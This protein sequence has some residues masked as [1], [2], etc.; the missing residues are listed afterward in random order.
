MWG[1]DKGRKVGGGRCRRDKG[2]S[3][4]AKVYGVR[5][6]CVVQ[7]VT[8]RRLHRI[9]S[10]QETDDCGTA[11]VMETVDRVGGC[12]KQSS[13][14]DRGKRIMSMPNPKRRIY[15]MSHV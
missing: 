13:L 11:W 5:L 8:G 7:S 6:S 12:R 4:A 2:W 15:S 1:E 10:S 9:V 3:V 14:Y